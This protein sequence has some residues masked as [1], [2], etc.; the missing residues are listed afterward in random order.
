MKNMVNTGILAVLFA[1]SCCAQDALL[2]INSK[3]KQRVSSFEVNKIY[4]HPLSLVAT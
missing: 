3:R 1:T 4:V 2:T